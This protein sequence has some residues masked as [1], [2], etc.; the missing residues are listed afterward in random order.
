MYQNVFV[1]TSCSN[2]TDLKNFH[3]HHSL[4]QFIILSNDNS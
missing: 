3:F 2:L 4:I 1:I